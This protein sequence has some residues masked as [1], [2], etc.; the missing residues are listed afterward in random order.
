M[1]DVYYNPEKYDLTPVG[2]IYMSE[3]CW[4]FDIVAVW[5]HT[6]TGDLYWGRD[7]GCSCPSPFE[8]YRSLD[9]LTKL[10]SGNL[11]EFAQELRGCYKQDDANDLLRKV[12]KALRG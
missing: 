6:P 1:P 2:E 9:K 5:Q 10:S 3:P 7:M 12:R 4:D 8:D 11:A